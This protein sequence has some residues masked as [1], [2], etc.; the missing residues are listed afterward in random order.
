MGAQGVVIASRKPLLADVLPQV[1]K[2]RVDRVS[3]NGRG[4]W[5]IEEVD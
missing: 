4:C 5:V 2:E 3:A 1:N